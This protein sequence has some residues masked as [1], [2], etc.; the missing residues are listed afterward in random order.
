LARTDL[1][2]PH[3]RRA[4]QA[5]SVLGQRI[6]L[7]HLRSL[8]RESQYNCD[9]LVRN[10]L[11]RLTRDGLQF[12]H[13]LVRDGAYGSLTNARKRESHGAAAA[14][15]ADDPVLRAEH[16]DRTGEPE[17]ARA[18][19]GAAIAQAILF[20]QDQAIAL[21][22]RGLALA[23]LAHETFELAMLVR[24]LQLDAGRG[25]EALDAYFQAF[26][27]ASEDANRCRALLGCAS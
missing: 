17:A 7:A 27:V 8:L 2:S 26:A 12:A 25:T 21:A 4:T 22:A 13:A 14:I 6:S 20:R 16:L 11:L 10:V 18:Y 15:F 3:D 1:L 23:I 19:L 5:A 24:D 9:T